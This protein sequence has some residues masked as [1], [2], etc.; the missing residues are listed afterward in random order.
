MATV[1]NRYYNSPWLADVGRNLASAFAIPDVD[2]LREREKA[3]W[4]F[5]YAKTKAGN[6]VTD[7][8]NKKFA[9]E[10]IGQITGLF[11]HP[12]LDAKGEMDVDAMRAAAAG[13]MKAAI[14]RGGPEV[15]NEV[16]AA[17]GPLSAAFV[18]KQKLRADIER[19][20]YGRQNDRQDFTA[21]ESD[22]D[23]EAR[24]EL[25]ARE[26]AARLDYLTQQ[27]DQR[28]AEINARNIAEG[29]SNAITLT[30]A[31]GKAIMSGIYQRINSTGMK[32]DDA[33]IYRLFDQVADDTSRVTRNYATSLS[34]VWDS[35]FPG[36]VYRRKRGLLDFGS[37]D[38]EY[39]SPNFEAALPAFGDDAAAAPA[40]TDQTTL[41]TAGEQ[42]PMSDGIE[43]P[44]DRIKARGDN[45]RETADLLAKRQAANAVPAAKTPAAGKS[46]GGDA[47]TPPLS[48]LFP[49]GKPTR[50]PSNGQIWQNQN[51]R[52]VRRFD[53][54][55]EYKKGTP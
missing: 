51:G 5:E 49:N 21:T 12:I 54:E 34:R 25:Q 41:P 29:K 19:G 8:E 24:F 53:L 46:S 3:A 39:L 50:F 47:G 37:G 38:D 16:E 40:A 20:L 2:K 52:A 9:S 43:T 17:A 1:P 18:A 55:A 45:E 14:E 13:F 44:Y 11:E 4:E 32:L 27:G 22:K 15:V 10:Q 36:G 35:R 48:K 6:E 30:P 28:I 31:M 42:R 7:R 33:A 26:H 23:R